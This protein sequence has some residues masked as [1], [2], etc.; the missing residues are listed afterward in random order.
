MSYKGCLCIFSL[1]KKYTRERLINACTMALEFRVY[2][3][4][5]VQKILEKEMGIF[6]M[7]T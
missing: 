1:E 7:N 5:I 2:K 3:D 6:Q 4:N